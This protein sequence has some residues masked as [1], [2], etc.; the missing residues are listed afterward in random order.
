MRSL[1]DLSFGH[2]FALAFDAT[3]PKR[4]RMHWTTDVFP[5]FLAGAQSR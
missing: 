1:N 2:A 3:N 5:W 4:A